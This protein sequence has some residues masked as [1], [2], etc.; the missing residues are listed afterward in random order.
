MHLSRVIFG[1]DLALQ[2]AVTPTTDMVLMIPMT[3]TQDRHDRIAGYI[4]ASVPLARL[5]GVPDA[6]R[7]TA[8]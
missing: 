7:Q 8:I 5:P 6:V 2:Y 3:G 1:D 4:A